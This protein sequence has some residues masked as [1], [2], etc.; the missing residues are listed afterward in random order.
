MKRFITVIVIACFALGLFGCATG[1]GTG[2]LAGGAIGAG[3]GAAVSRKNPL[4]GALIGATLGAIAGAAIG[5]YVDE[6]KE[7]RQESIR[8]L[9]YKPSQGNMVRIEDATTN[10]VKVKPGEVVGLNTTYYVLNP[11]SGAQVKIVE[12]RVIRYNGKPVIEPM[13]REVRKEQGLT[14]STARLPIPKDAAEGEY[15][16]VTTI[17]NGSWQD[18]SVSKFYVQK[19]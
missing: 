2:V 19:L 10:P 18:K 15:T 3:V 14:S 6:Q 7:N 8:D 4:L 13:V 9:D 12:T 17:D 1:R 11:S 16:V 5:N